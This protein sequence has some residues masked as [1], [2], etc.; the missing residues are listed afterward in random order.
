M[1]CQY[2]SPGKENKRVTS[3]DAY[4]VCLAPNGSPTQT[5]LC[6]W[7]GA[8]DW[9]GGYVAQRT[10][11]KMFQL[12]TQVPV[13]PSPWKGSMW[14]CEPDEPKWVTKESYGAE[15]LWVPQAQGLYFHQH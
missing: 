9:P 6:V 11:E 5:G 15:M 13:V 1:E 12:P 7:A 4:L 2:L 10:L 8:T 3:G 14:V